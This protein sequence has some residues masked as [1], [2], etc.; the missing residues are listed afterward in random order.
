MDE[1]FEIENK[2]IAKFCDI[3]LKYQNHNIMIWGNSDS[4]E[5]LSGE[6]Q[7]HCSWDW[8]MPVVEKIE[9]KGFEFNITPQHVT[10]INSEVTLIK[11][12]HKSKILNTWLCVVQFIK[13]YNSGTFN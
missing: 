9:S 8:L 6:L 3:S 1:L 11:T 4:T 5:I 10:I 12:F 13:L 2:L 7:Y